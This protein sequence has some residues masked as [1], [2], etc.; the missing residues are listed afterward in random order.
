MTGVS[1]G[2]MNLDWLGT[3]PGWLTLIGGIVAIKT[4][5]R[6]ASLRIQQA[7]ERRL[8]DVERIHVAGQAEPDQEPRV[9]LV[10]D[11][12]RTLYEVYVEL[13]PLDT[14]DEDAA[15]VMSLLG[16]DLR[17]CVGGS[18]HELRNER[19]DGRTVRHLD[20]SYAWTIHGTTADGYR[21]EIRSDQPPRAERA[22][23]QSSS[24]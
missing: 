21:V 19:F 4:Y 7:D 11:S 24:S 10:N 22:Q 12:T 1:L 5:R 14:R 13:R 15:D 23:P 2:G 20:D 8:V 17:R 6:D 9:Q 18:R 3:V 16:F